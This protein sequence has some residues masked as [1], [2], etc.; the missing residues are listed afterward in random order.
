[1]DRWALA[2]SQYWGRDQL[3]ALTER[4]LN[5]LFAAVAEIPF[6]KETFQKHPRGTLSARE[7]LATL[8]VISRSTFKE[9]SPDTY[10]SYRH[11]EGS[12]RET[13]SGSTGIPFTF[14][15]DRG[16]LLS[17]RAV[18]DRDYCN[19][20]GGRYPMILLRADQGIQTRFHTS[21]FV[22]LRSLA[23]IPDRFE[24]LAECFEQNAPRGGILYTFP[25][26][27]I[28]LAQYMEQNKKTLPVKAVIGS[29]ESVSPEN[30]AMLERVFK[31]RF[32]LQ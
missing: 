10:V 2:R 15:L 24:A 7:Y 26:M 6:W 12:I 4:R 5:K 28:A 17:T 19:A 25:S 32:M 18:R 11:L 22:Y 29:G 16:A 27:A 14:F 31:A 3:D 23:D 8:P 1:M 21:Y 9:I 20:A 13:T 30:R